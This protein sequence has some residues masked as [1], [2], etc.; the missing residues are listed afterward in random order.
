MVHIPVTS[1][2]ASFRAVNGNIDLVEVN[3]EAGAPDLSRDVMLR[4]CAGRNRIHARATPPDVRA[5]WCWHHPEPPGSS[6]GKD[7][8]GGHGC[9]TT[10]SH[11]PGA[12][13]CPARPP[14]PP[15][16]TAPS[17]PRSM[18]DGRH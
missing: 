1:V 6:L 10:V 13:R 3:H 15:P 12:P 7:A 16:S 11:Q 17:G 2:A 14:G 4:H 8:D 9:R 5:G 18:A